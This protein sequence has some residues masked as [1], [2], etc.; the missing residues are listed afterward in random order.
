M[1]SSTLSI[2]V[3]GTGS[4]GLRHLTLLSQMPGVTVLAA[5][6]RE[7]RAAELAAK[8]FSCVAAGVELGALPFDGAVIATDTSSH[9]VDARRFRPGCGLLIEKPIA[10]DAST[11]VTL[12]RERS[13]VACV[14][15]FNPGLVWLKERLPA[16]GALQFVDAECLSWLPAWRPAHDYRESY[17]ARVGEGG[18]LRDLIHEVD[19]LHWLFGPAR[20]VNGTVWNSGTLGLS[21]LLDE[22]AIASLTTREG[23]RI[24]LRLSFAMNP[25]SRTLRVWGEHGQLRWDAVARRASLVSPAGAELEAMTW[26][27][28]TTMY[29]EQLAHWVAGL[30]GQDAGQLAT[31]DDGIAALRVVDALRNSN[32]REVV[33]S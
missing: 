8:G 28:P 27:D 13:H 7:G 31:L 25:T 9:V 29:S 16:L 5:P 17:S 26:G 6:K 21:P 18:V 15:R 22:S 10:I 3:V 33:I 1:S 4:I 30:R 2:C 23:L 12:G 32:G 20:S 14:L 19:Y 11:A 24:A